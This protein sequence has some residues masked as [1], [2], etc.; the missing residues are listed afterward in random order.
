[1]KTIVLYLFEPNRKFLS[2][3]AP[4][5]KIY[6]S[7][8]RSVTVAYMLLATTMTFWAG[9]AIVGR[10]FRD[11][12]PPI[13]LAFLRWSI[14]LIVILLI[15]RPPLRKDAAVLFSSWRILLVT[16]TFGIGIFNTL[17]YFALQ[18]TTAINVGL[19]QVMMPISILILDVLWFGVRARTSQIIGMLLATLGVVIILCRGDLT[20]LTKLTVN[21]GDLIM[22]TA[23]AL[24]AIFAVALRLKPNVHPW[25]FLAVIFAIGALEL[26]PFAYLEWSSGARVVV[27]EGTILAIAYVVIGPAI[28][29]YTFFTKAVETLGPNNAGMFFYYI[30][31]ATAVLAVL[32]LEEP[33]EFFHMIG[34]ILTT[35]GLRFA[36]QRPSNPN[37]TD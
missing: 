3:L 35:L 37:S 1:M 31:V 10:L 6:M 34:F 9:N 23:V 25:S 32:I 17:Q 20:V 36:L 14:A 29:A 27:S 33:L 18:Y 22:L 8:Q 12:L 19:M 30:P 7:L 21:I 28:L 11:E 26:L 5:D 16:G 15:I 24:Y 13:T 2:F 4:L